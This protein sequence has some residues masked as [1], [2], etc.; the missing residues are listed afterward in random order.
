MMDNKKL[1]DSVLTEIELTVSKANFNT[2]FKDTRIID[3]R[4][5]II[6]VSVPNQFARDW[7]SD[8]F[9][10]SILKFLRNFSE[11]IRSVEYTISKEE[12]KRRDDHNRIGMPVNELPLNDFYIN[13]EDNLKDRKST[14]LN[15]SH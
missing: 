14:R 3:Q 15:S 8:K 2:W 1:W 7:L 5:G 10:R 9:H 11:N 6:S 13:K 4:D 12:P